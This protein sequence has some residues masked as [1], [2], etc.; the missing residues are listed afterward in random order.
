MRNVFFSFHYQNDIFRANVVRN[1]WIGAGGPEP[2]GYRDWSMWESARTRNDRRLA[3]MIAD[4]M[5]GSSVA[6]VLIGEETAERDWILHE[7]E[8]SWH[9][10]KGLLGIYIHQVRDMRTGRG[11]PPG[12]NPF[13]GVYMEDAGGDE[14]HLA[15]VVDIYDWKDDDG[16]YNFG[17]WVEQAA[18]DAGR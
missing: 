12:R 7:I 17:D 6:A 4:A 10:G 18:Q 1:A 15:E 2:A 11:S 8:A 13:E 16:F 9:L 3:G 5:H 14:V